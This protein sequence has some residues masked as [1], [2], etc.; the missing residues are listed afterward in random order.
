MRRERVLTRLRYD[1]NVALN[2]R[3]GD[4]IDRDPRSAKVVDFV[5]ELGSTSLTRVVALRGN[6]ED[7]WP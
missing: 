7:A 1:N 6:R 3:V 4:Y 2:F 5:R